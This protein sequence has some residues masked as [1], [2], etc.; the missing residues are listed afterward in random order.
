MGEGVGFRDRGPELEELWL[1]VGVGY[2]VRRAR[3]HDAW[4]R[5]ALGVLLARHSC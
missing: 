2:W 1:R 5:L 4:A 3:L